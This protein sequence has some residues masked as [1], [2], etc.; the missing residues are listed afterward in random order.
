MM[1]RRERLRRT[2]TSRAGMVVVFAYLFVGVMLPCQ[3]AEAA[4]T[5]ETL[6]PSV[7]PAAER[8]IAVGDI[9]GDLEAARAALRLGGVLDQDDRWCGGTTVLV[10]TGDLLDRGDDEQA[11][12][13][14]F[15]RLAREAAAEGGAVHV[16]HGN[17]ELLNIELDFRYVTE[18]GF[19]DFED[20][21]GV[22]QALAGLDSN[23]TLQAALEGLDRKQHARA[24][25][26][27]PG[28]PAAR[29]LASHPVVLQI[30]QILFVHAGLRPV[31]AGR[32]LEAINRESHDWLLGLRE[33]PD[34]TDAYK[35]PVWSRDFSREVDQDDC[36]LLSK[37]LEILGARAMVVGH[38]VHDSITSYCDG[39]VWCID[40]GLAAHY[41]GPVEVLE[42][43][44][45]RHEVLRADRPE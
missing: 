24:A 26:F 20:S 16:L 11:L 36:R 27:A 14:L 9:H 6:P 19:A 25:A 4:V 17:H 28:G 34:W 42:I 30:G 8:I 35:G 31:H 3:A 7:L 5:P 44:D 37:T 40:V 18:A 10:Q 13:E 38:T 12:L 33:Q 45:T 39:R 23:P 29:L 21:P 15:A 43:R 2:V 41:G 1:N 22:S 32:G